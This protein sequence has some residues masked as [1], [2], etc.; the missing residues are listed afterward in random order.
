MYLKGPALIALSICCIGAAGLAHQVQKRQGGFD[1]PA[2][3]VAAADCMEIGFDTPYGRV[4][5]LTPV[6]LP[7][8][9]DELQAD[10]I[11]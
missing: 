10:A 9:E 3:T 8:V 11:D 7:L 2:D 6:I 5:C 1:G 4:G